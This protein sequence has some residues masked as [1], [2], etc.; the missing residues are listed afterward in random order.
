MSS[1]KSRRVQ[2]LVSR[3]EAPS[4]ADEPS[5][6]RREGADELKKLPPRSG[7]GAG[8]D[9]RA[10]AVFKCS[11]PSG[12]LD[13]ERYRTKHQGH[14]SSTPSQGE[15]ARH[16]PEGAGGAAGNAAMVSHSKGGHLPA[17][18][19]NGSMAAEGSA[20]RKHAVPQGLN[21]LD[22][23]LEESIPSSGS[24]N[25][26]RSSSSGQG[27]ETGV[28]SSCSSWEKYPIAPNSDSDL[29]SIIGLT[30]GSLGSLGSSGTGRSSAAD[31][32][33]GQQRAR[34]SDAGAGSGSSKEKHAPPTAQAAV[35]TGSG[36]NSSSKKMSV[37]SAA[38]QGSL[39]DVTSQRVGE[40]SSGECGGGTDDELSALS[41]GGRGRG[42]GRVQPGGPPGAWMQLSHPQRANRAVMST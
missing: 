38:A 35:G 29:D 39:E 30:S 8:D 12:I 23:G 41:A 18:Q 22:E 21:S 32:S 16:A 9:S 5:A 6:E 24:G 13:S 40:Q 20:G 1:S 26:A 17:L 31:Q 27:V 4:G 33:D 34:V 19:A 15:A 7:A 3:F 28:S 11:G 10:Y 36:I 25:S 37:P 2:Q 42:M 14:S